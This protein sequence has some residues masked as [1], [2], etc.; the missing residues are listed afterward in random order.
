M[1]NEHAINWLHNIKDH[2]GGDDTFD[3]LKIE[4]I[5]LAIKALQLHDDFEKCAADEEI[6]KSYINACRNASLNENS[7][8]YFIYYEETGVFEVYITETR[9]LFEKRHCSKHMSDDEFHKIVT[10]Y[11]DSYP[12]LP[13]APQHQLG[14]EE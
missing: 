1:T 4:A 9:E 14:D 13:F 5:D 7:P 12:A 3:A 6:E 8:L 11:L 2:I 10:L